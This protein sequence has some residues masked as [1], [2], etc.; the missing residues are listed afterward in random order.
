MNMI[1]PLLQS[2][3]TSAVIM[4]SA[5]ASNI[6]FVYYYP[7]GGGTD[8]WSV[9]VIDGFIARGHT[10]R[11]EYFKS[12]HDALAFAKT[13]SD[14][15]FVVTS[16]LDIQPTVSKR[17]PSQNSQPGLNFVTNISGGSFYLCTSPKHPNITFKDLQGDRRYTIGNTSADSAMLPWKT[18]LASDP[19]VLNV[20]MIPYGGQAELRAAAIAGTDIELIYM[21]SNLETITSTGG[22]CIAS[23]TAK[24]HLNLPWLGELAPGKFM[25]TYQTFELWG[26]ENIRSSEIAVLKEIFQSQS[27]K[28][29]LSDRPSFVH[30]GLGV[31]VDAGHSY[32]IK[33]MELLNPK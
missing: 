10:V 5:H 13:Q 30:K 29:Y 18:L 26:F 28:D 7:P 25:N 14:P 20:T 16:G 22:V 12:C 33:L 23:S 21:S 3:L 19:K 15:T 9:P 11:K 27:F 32:Q 1:K 2:L 8:A 6:N 4:F 24:N 31:E 17:C